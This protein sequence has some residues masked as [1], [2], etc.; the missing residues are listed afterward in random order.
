[1]LY[2]RV[3]KAHA[4]TRGS[5]LEKAI[6]DSESALFALLDELTSTRNGHVHVSRFEDSEVARLSLWESLE[7]DREKLR[8]TGT[9]SRMKR[10]IGP[11]R[12]LRT[13]NIRADNKQVKLTLGFAFSF[14]ASHMFTDDGFL[15][16]PARLAG[17]ESESA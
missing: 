11:A 7:P 6:K 14:L 8:G 16:I 17:H 13:E 5:I 15:I 1:M 3:R 2:V 9:I 4:P 12:K 10:D